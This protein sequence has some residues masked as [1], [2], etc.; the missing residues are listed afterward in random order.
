MDKLEKSRQIGK[1]ESEKNEVKTKLNC[2]SVET[3][4]LFKTAE[5]SR[6]W[7]EHNPH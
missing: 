7:Q 5:E 4:P 3:C 6:T 1:A 2:E